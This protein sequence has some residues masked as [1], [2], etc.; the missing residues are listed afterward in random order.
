MKEFSLDVWIDGACAFR[1][2]GTSWKALLAQARHVRD[3]APKGSLRFVG[4]AR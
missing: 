3:I 1:L 2:F 4:R